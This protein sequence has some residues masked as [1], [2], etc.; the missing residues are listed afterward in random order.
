MLRVGIVG[1]GFMG[2]IHYQ[3]YQRAKGAKVTALCSRDEKKLAGDW[4]GIKGNFGPPGQMMDLSGVKTYRTLEELLADKDVDLVD[5]CLPPAMHVEAGVAALQA[6]KHVFCEKPIAV[7][8]ADADAMVAAAKKSGKQLLIGQVLPFFPEYAFALDAIRGGKYG[9]LL[10]GHFKRI[11][12]EPTWIPDFFDPVKIGGPA[13]DLHVH[14]AHFIRLVCGMPNAVFTTGRLRGQ[15]AEFFQT[16]FLFANRQLHVTAA[17]GV[18]G[19]QGRPFTHGFEIYLRDATL[20]MDFAV[21]GDKP[22]SAYPLTVLQRDGSVVTPELPAGDHL[23]GFVAEIEEAV[24][25]ITGG[26]ISPLL[27]GGMARDALLLCH[28][29][30][31]SLRTGKFVDV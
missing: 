15:V 30:E 5:V 6:G 4:R 7:T 12:S 22:T 13:V 31:E 10:G 2:M 20:I 26:T 14:D 18:I 27:D 1:I 25:A 21:L 29:Q 3:A 17:S 8:V 19:Q 23:T 16:Q 24:Q 28:K 11:I 9:P